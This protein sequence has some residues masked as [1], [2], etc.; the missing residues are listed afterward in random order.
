MNTK[1]IVSILLLTAPLLL[2]AQDNSTDKAWVINEIYASKLPTRLGLFVE[3]YNPLSD[4]IPFDLYLSTNKK[5]PDLFRIR[6]KSHYNPDLRKKGYTAFKISR[7]HKARSILLYHIVDTLYLFRKTKNEYSL[8]DQLPI[9]WSDTLSIGRCGKRICYFNVGT[10]GQPNKSVNEDQLI[11]RKN[12]RISV[13][14]GTSSANNTGFSDG[15]GSTPSFGVKAQKN[16]NRRL[17]YHA[18]SAALFTQGY[19]FKTPQQ[20]T[21][22]ATGEFVRSAEGYYRSIQFWAG[23]EIGVFI[24][25]RLDF[26]CGAA[27]V[28]GSF[29]WQRYDEK[30]IFTPVNG[31]PIQEHRKQNQVIGN[32]G[33][34]VLTFNAGL[35]YELPSRLKIELFHTILFR[36][37]EKTETIY[38]K[39]FNIGVSVPFSAMGRAYRDALTSLLIQG[40]SPD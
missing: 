14:G 23:E 11:P 19:L 38:Y 24:T 25:P 30:R 17:F 3:L 1:A 7:Y 6:I 37:F 9:L 12:Y 40:T 5:M 22:T 39:S 36:T 34:P 32:Y 29:S 27:L 18:I 31:I 21:V 16:T 33:L 4:K 8:Q 15:V 10:P 26:S 35:N 2:S 28:L 13:L 20:T